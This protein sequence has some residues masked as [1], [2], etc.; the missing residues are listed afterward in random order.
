MGV[1]G[2]EILTR[3]DDADLARR[4]RERDPEALEEVARAYLGQ[5][6]RA[7]RG[8]GL[9]VADAEDVTQAT[10]KTFV[11]RAGDFEGRSRVR[12][13]LFGI[14]YRKIGEARRKTRR[15]VDVDDID[16]VMESRF[17]P[18]GT[19][20]RPPRSADGELRDREIRER[21]EGCLE[22]LPDRQKSAFLLREVDGFGTEEICKILD[23]T[24]TNLGVLFFRARNRLR[25]CLEVGG[26]GG[27]QD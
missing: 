14:L 16:E 8:A 27:E 18:D 20:L 2:E 11:E 1:R 10:F 26:H 21:L 19:W 25:E 6:F 17:R 9:D 7:A 3:A 23:V 4:V 15:S 22:A 5:I 24:V 12:T 13:W